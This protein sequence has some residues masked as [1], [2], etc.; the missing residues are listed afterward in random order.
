MHGK[1]HS[2]KMISNVV[3][4]ILV[5]LSVEVDPEMLCDIQCLVGQLIGKAE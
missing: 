5:R 1:M 3:Q 4:P 2:M